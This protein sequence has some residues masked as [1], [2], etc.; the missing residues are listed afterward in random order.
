MI[1]LAM[2]WKIKIHSHSPFP[3]FK[4]SKTGEGEPMAGKYP[5][6]R[7]GEKEAVRGRKNARKSSRKAESW[8]SSCTDEGQGKQTASWRGGQK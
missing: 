1:I 4:E 6:G 2:T 3:L 8:R 5:K 7:G